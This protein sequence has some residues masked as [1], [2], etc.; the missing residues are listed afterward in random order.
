MKRR[1]RNKN[2]LNDWRNLGYC[3][4]KKRHRFLCGSRYAKTSGTPF[5]SCFDNNCS[6]AK[7]EC[8]HLSSQC[9]VDNIRINVFRLKLSVLFTSNHIIQRKYYMYVTYVLVW[10]KQDAVM[11]ATIPGK[12]S[13]THMFV[14]FQRRKLNVLDLIKPRRVKCQSHVISMSLNVTP[15]V[16]ALLT[17]A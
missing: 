17:C 15:Q 13:S 3:L 14:C 1:S 4:F 16:V 12:F 2:V 5:S 6:S 7:K 10:G 9:A 8:R 11:V